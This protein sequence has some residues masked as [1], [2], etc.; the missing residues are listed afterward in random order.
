[1]VLAPVVLIIAI[2]IKVDSRGPIFYRSVRVGRHGAEFAMIKFRKMYDGAIGSALTA[3]DDG[4]FTR[5]GRV[6]A[7]TKLDE[8]PQLFNVLIGQM[9][10]VGPRPEDAR[11]VA[12]EAETYRTILSVRPGITG[13]SQLAF[14]RE[15]EV[16]DP[17]DR[18]GH[19]VRAIFPQKL[20]LDMLY[21]TRRS[22]RL[23]LRILAWTALAV[24][25][26]REVA[27]N[28]ESGKLTR[29]HREEIRSVVL[30]SSQAA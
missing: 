18:V 13:L 19:Y 20:A 14:A 22:I 8:L 26:H 5:V 3:A 21:A 15:S 16:L 28:R 27:V 23:D 30:E 9:S 29:R 2:A 10:I 17:S 4:R 1:M 12:L 25:A 11:F 7:R 6:L 24:V